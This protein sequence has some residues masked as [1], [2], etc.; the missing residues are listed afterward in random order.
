MKN[1]FLTC[2]IMSKKAN[3]LTA[4]AAA[5][6]IATSPVSA[7]TNNQTEQQKIEQKQTS[8]QIEKVTCST[9][10]A[11]E[12]LSLSIQAQIDELKAKGF[13]NLSR[14]EKIKYGSLKKELIAVEKAETAQEKAET[15]ARLAKVEERLDSIEGSLQSK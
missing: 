12:K 9:K 10:L 11:C 15:Q 2:K 1:Y 6:A 13:R 7:D 5:V 4:M 14:E 8:K 3:A